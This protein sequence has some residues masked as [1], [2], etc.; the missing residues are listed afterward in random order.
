MS[1]AVVLIPLECLRCRTRLPAEEGQVA[2]VCPACGQG[3]RLTEESVLKELPIQ[4]AAAASAAQVHWFAFWVLKGQVQIVERLSYGR[5][6]AADPRWEASQTF[7]LPGFETT[8]EEAVQWGLRFLR[9]PVRLAAGSAASLPPVTVG[10]EEAQALAEFVVLSFE[11][12][13]RDKLKS[14]RAVLD[15]G[16]PELWCLPFAAT[17]SSWKLALAP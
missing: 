13:R 3:Q 17:G 14:L 15:L 5:D 6:Q 12:D 10:P 7:V 16:A 1:T 8:P 2:W 11:A 4:F 9:E